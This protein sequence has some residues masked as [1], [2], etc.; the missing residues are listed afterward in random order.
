MPRPEAYALRRQILILGP[1]ISLLITD[2]RITPLQ[3]ALSCCCCCCRPVVPSLSVSGMT[4]VNFLVTPQSPISAVRA[5]LII[6]AG[7]RGRV[8]EKAGTPFRGTLRRLTILGGRLHGCGTGRDRTSPC[9]QWAGLHLL[10]GGWPAPW[11]QNLN[12]ARPPEPPSFELRWALFLG[13][14]VFW[15]LGGRVFRCGLA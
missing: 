3:P 14:V 15:G 6:R 4:W 2:G 13:S 10:E 5:T 8:R 11:P 12:D 7:R 1:S 9:M